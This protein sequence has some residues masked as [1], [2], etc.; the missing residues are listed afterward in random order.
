[1]KSSVKIHLWL[2]WKK[3]LRLHSRIIFTTTTAIIIITTIIIIWIFISFFI[4]CFQC[5]SNQMHQILSVLMFWDMNTNIS[6]RANKVRVTQRTEICQEVKAYNFPLYKR[7]SDERDV[8]ISYSESC[9]KI[10]N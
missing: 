5:I 3:P 7:S 1:M 9:P 6:T 4:I 8:E 2:L 10:Q